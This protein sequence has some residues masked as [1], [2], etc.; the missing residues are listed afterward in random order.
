MLF[1][2]VNNYFFSIDDLIHQCLTTL[3]TL[4]IKLKKKIKI[5][6]ELCFISTTIKY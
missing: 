6:K 4:H 3:D 1:P 2:D 5:E